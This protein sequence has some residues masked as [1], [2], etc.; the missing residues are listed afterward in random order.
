MPGGSEPADLHDLTLVRS[1]GISEESH[2]FIAPGEAR[3]SARPEPPGSLSIEPAI[4]DKRGRREMTLMTTPILVL[5][6]AVAAAVIFGI[7][8]GIPMW[9]IRRHPDTAPDNGLPGYL[10]ADCEN[11]S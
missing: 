11:L 3:L 5:I 8:A 1:R 2:E 4:P 7:F 6:Y 9:M 10:R